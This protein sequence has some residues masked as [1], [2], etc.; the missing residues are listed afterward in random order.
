YVMGAGTG[1][2]EKG[3][4]GGDGVTVVWGGEAGTA[5]G[6]F[7]SCLIWST[8][9]GREVPVMMVVSNN[10]WGIST[11]ACSVHSEKRVIDRGRAHGIPGEGGDGNDPIASWYALK[12]AFHHCPTTPRPFMLEARGARMDE[13]PSSDAA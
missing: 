8:M 4:E 2:V 6:D 12:R 3:G 9:P 10:G 7:A 5:E 13:H 1:M 11:P